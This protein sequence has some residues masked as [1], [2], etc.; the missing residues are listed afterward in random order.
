LALGT[1]VV[2]VPL[3]WLAVDIGGSAKLW[4]IWVVIA[5][6]Y[7]AGAAAV[8]VW[9]RRRRQPAGRQERNDALAGPSQGGRMTRII[10]GQ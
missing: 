1:L 9:N 2:G 10:P 3:S 4:H 7:G 6:A 5:I 8:L